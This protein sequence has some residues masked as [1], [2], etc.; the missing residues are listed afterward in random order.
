[1]LRASA[2]AGAARTSVATGR[3]SPDPEHQRGKGLMVAE[4]AAIWNQRN[5]EFLHRNTIPP[6]DVDGQRAAVAGSGA[7]RVAASAGALID[8]RCLLEMKLK[9]RGFDRKHKNQTSKR[10]AGLRSAPPNPRYSG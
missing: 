4:L 10:S 5:S 2:L 7:S 8:D 3:S 6:L 9:R 1:M